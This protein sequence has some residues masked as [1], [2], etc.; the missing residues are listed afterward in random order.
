VLPWLL[1]AWLAGAWV[2]PPNG[3]LR[4]GAAGGFALLAATVAAYLAAAGD[5]ASGMA[6]R[7]IV[8][9]IVTGP[10]FG[11]AGAAV[12]RGPGGRQLAVLALVAAVVGQVVVLM[13]IGPIPGG[14][15]Y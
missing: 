8:L 7:L 5:A 14:A 4:W 9:A 2:S 15:G 11:V 10:L 12:H 6:F 13:V 3:S 1:A